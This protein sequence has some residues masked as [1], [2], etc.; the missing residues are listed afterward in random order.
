MGLTGLVPSLTLSN[1]DSWLPPSSPSQLT[2]TSNPKAVQGPA[3]L[4]PKQVH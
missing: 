4:K 1:R 3:F 2:P